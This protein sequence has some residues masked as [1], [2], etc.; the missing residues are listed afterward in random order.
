ME[1]HKYISA[2]PVTAMFKPEQANEAMGGLAISEELVKFQV[3][4]SH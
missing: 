3:I 2:A 4:S 1:H